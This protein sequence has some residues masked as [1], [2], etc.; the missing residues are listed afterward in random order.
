[1]YIVI[2]YAVYLAISLALT[3]WV[4]HTLERNGRVFLWTLFRATRNWRIR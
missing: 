4:A 3:V 1:M 2:S